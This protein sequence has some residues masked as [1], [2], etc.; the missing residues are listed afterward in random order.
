M[1]PAACERPTGVVLAGGRSSRMGTDKAMVRVGGVAMVRRVADALA[2]G[3][4]DPVWCQGGD[5]AR[6]H[7]IGLEVRPD[8]V[9]HG[10]LLAAIAAALRSAAPADVVVAACDLPDLDAAT[11]AAL[12]AAGERDRPL[13]AAASDP[14]GTHLAAW[15]S[16]EAL[17]PLETLRA[18]GLASYRAAVERLGGLSVPV[19]AG[20]VRNVNDPGDL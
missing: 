6:L 20:A 3:G 12:I 4:C 8:P 10:G 13:V 15:W 1:P 2:A 5:T 16:A 9:A 11:V 14:S 7:A 17:V 18:A 19:A